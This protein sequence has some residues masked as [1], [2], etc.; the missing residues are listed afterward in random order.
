MSTTT[1]HYLL[2]DAGCAQCTDLAGEI[3]KASG[4]ALLG[5]SLYAPEAQSLL[6]RARPNWKFE[7]TLIDVRGEQVRAYTGMAMRVH[8]VTFLNPAQLLKIARLV[9]Q[10]GVPLF[11]SVQKP[12]PETIAKPFE[13]ETENKLELPAG[14][15]LTPVGPDLGAQSPVQTVTTTHGETIQLGQGAGENNLLLFLSTHCTFCHKVAAALSDLVE[16]T[17]ERVI[18]V[19]GVSDPTELDEFLDKY[20]LGSLPIVASPEVRAAFGVTGVPYGFALDEN[21]IVRGKGIVNNN[22]HLDSLA[23]T[24]YVSVEAFKQALAS[25]KE[26]KVVVT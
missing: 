9:Q 2:F 16:D 14:F 17:P 13:A 23:N 15:S 5:M 3:E 24:F 8:M 4:G 7:P 18:L 25:R 21:G 26:D 20:Q 22:D 6:N 1:T 19:F 10:A 12:M 11:R